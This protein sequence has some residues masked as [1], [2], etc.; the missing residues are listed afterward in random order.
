M[1]NEVIRSSEGSRRAVDVVGVDAAVGD[2]VGVGDGSI[3]TDYIDWRA[4]SDDLMTSLL[5]V[6]FQDGVTR[7][8]TRKEVLHYTQVVAGAGN[9]TTGELAGW[10]R[11]SLNIPTSAAKS[12]KTGH[13]CCAP[14]TRPYGSKPTGP[15]VARYAI[16]DLSRTTPR[17]PRAV[18]CSCCS[19]PPTATR[20]EYEDPDTFNIHRDNIST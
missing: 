2:L 13:C 5:D 12:T 20:A 7:K 11:C 16:R 3:Y 19:G 1:S 4:D 15:H 6:E 17:C 10:P 8:L 9:E 18:P 14:S